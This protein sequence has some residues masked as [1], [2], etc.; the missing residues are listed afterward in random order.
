MVT[1]KQLDDKRA[2][3]YNKQ[4][5]EETIDA[6]L[7]DDYKNE[8]YHKVLIKKAIVSSVCKEIAEKYHSFGWNYVYYSKNNA[9]TGSTLFV[10][11]QNE[12]PEYNTQ[13]YEKIWKG[14]RN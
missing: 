3:E 5:I 12:E 7:L 14:F 11:S 13:D 1:P 4:L 9:V 2:S 6:A 8:S 10:F